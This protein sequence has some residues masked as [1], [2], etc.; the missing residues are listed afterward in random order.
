MCPGLD[1]ELFQLGHQRTTRLSRR[2][3]LTISAACAALPTVARAAPLARWR[4]T[5]LEPPAGLQLVGLSD[6]QAAPIIA[7]LEA[8]LDRL[9]N[10]FS[11][12]RPDSHLIRRNRDGTLPAPAPELLQV[13]TQSAALYDATGVAFDPIVQPLWMALAAGAPDAEVERARALMLN[14]IAQGAGA[15][16]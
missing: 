11:L 13:L 9:E 14:G 12:Y 10:I 4:G 1:L 5:A 6:T 3:F 8:E 7:A 2:C 15:D 16:R